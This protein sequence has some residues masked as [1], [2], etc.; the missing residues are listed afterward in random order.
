VADLHDYINQ[1]AADMVRH[2]FGDLDAPLQPGEY[3]HSAKGCP[4]AG[5]DWLLPMEWR[6]DKVLGAT[7]LR[8]LVEMDRL[9]QA[10]LEEHVAE[11]WNEG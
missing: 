3:V 10:H 5:C 9:A 8:G 6:H 11:N 4:H 1:A 2:G 7:R